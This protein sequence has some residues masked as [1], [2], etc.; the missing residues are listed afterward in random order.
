VALLPGTLAEFSLRVDMTAGVRALAVQY[1][2]SD[3][4]LHWKCKFAAPFA[5]SDRYREGRDNWILTDETCK[6]VLVWTAYAPPLVVS[7]DP[8]R[9][10]SLGSILLEHIFH[11]VRS[12]FG[13]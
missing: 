8:V 12:A 2:H 11:D 6:K 5:I 1:L 3:I 7:P 4:L 9:A 10:S 13:G